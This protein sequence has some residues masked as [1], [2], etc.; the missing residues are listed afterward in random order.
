[1][2]QNIFEIPVSIDFQAHRCQWQI[3]DG[4]GEFVVET[5]QLP[6]H[7]DEVGE[8]IEKPERIKAVSLNPYEVREEFLK[9][10]SPDEILRFLRKT[11]RFTLDTAIKYA[12]F[13]DWQAQTRLL[14]VN[15]PTK[16]ANLISKD[17]LFMLR[18]H[19][20]FRIAFI[21]SDHGY[22]GC[23]AVLNTLHAIVA[24]VQL[25]HLRGAKHKFCKRQDCGLP[26]EIVSRHRRRYCSQYCAHIESV[27]RL[28]AR[29]KRSS[30]TQRDTHGDKI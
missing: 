21:W 30:K 7:F 16:W 27:R 10:S 22:S 11:G 17:F 14:M 25:D 8:L 13:K 12:D 29:R 3:D 18:S 9:A 6:L 5:E 28:R 1:M 19:D 24:T 2:A 23:I 4:R 20:S 26:F 15:P